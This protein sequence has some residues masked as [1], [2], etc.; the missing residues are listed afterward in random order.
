M[1]LVSRCGDDDCDYDCRPRQKYVK[2]DRRNKTPSDTSS[3]DVYKGA[4][5]CSDRY[6]LFATY[7]VYSST[8]V[9]SGDYDVTGIV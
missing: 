4:D 1:N 8:I 3:L 2:R 6:I 9:P 7:H 5:S